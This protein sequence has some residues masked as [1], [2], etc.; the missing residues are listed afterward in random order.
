MP[1]QGFADLVITPVFGTG[2]MI[3]EDALDKY[4][5]Q[6]LERRFTNSAVRLLLRGTLNPTR[7]FA[8]AL[9]FRHPWHRD[10]RPGVF[11]TDLSAEAVHRHLVAV[12]HEP[13]RSD[14]GRLTSAEAV[15]APFEFDLTFQPARYLGGQNVS[16]LGGSGTGAFRLAS[17]WQAVV[18]IGGCNLMGL[19]LDWSGDSLHYLA[20][21]RWVP[22]AAS[23]WSTH[24]QLLA[25]GEKVTH[26]QM[27]PDRKDF[28]YRQ[29]QRAGQIPEKKPTPSQYTSS[30]EANGFAVQTGTGV[31]YRL[32]P[33]LQWKVASLEYRYSHLPTLD[34]Q[35]YRGSLAFT[36]GLT[37]RMGT[38]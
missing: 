33:A 10:N 26:Q 29:W 30:N 20:G 21:V 1:Q 5:I 35:N 28:F 18:D 8:N 14:P 4:V 22:W 36:T 2:W 32:N 11:G 24:L 34:G 15:V 6:P 16:C 7:S 13:R 23:R 17:R 25:G 37:L 19:P 3:A 27:F 38:W 9:G 31:S 12:G